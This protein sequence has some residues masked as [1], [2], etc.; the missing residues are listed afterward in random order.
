MIDFIYIFRYYSL[1]METDKTKT[2]A[3]FINLRQRLNLT[4]QEIS[5]LFDVHV[6]TWKQWEYGDVVPFSKYLKLLDQ[7]EK[8]PPKLVSISTMC[9]FVRNKLNLKRYQMADLIGVAR[10]TWSFWEKGEMRPSN[11]YIEKIKQMYKEVIEKE[12]LQKAS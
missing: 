12:N 9:R 11:E 6:N 2:A 1:A 7:Y 4:Q 5:E 8:N 10:T 3:R